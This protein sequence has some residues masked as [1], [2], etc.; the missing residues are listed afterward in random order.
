[1]TYAWNFQIEQGVMNDAD[2]PYVAKDM[3]CR[4]D[5]AKIVGKPIKWERIWD[6]LDLV[7]ETLEK[8]P[9]TLLIDAS[10][11]E[12]RYYKSGIIQR[13]DCYNLLT[14]DFILCNH[15]VVLVGLYEPSNDDLPDNPGWRK[16]GGREPEP[17]CTVSKW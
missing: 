11:L 15:A 2:Y 7:K 5:E 10:A 3:R 17:T 1:M 12:F 9:M 4:H 6:D 8:T 13:E 16:S 14:K